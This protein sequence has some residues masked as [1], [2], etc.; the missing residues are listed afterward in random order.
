MEPE[1]P[2]KEKEEGDNGIIIYTKCIITNNLIQTN[3][4]HPNEPSARQLIEKSSHVCLLY[5]KALYALS[6]MENP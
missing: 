6:A 2:N 1:K 3:A 4:L 5:S